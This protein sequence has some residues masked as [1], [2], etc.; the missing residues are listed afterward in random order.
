[1]GIDED[2][3][4][5]EKTVS[6]NK[7]NIREMKAFMKG[8]SIAVAIIIG[9]GAYIIQDMVKDIKGNTSKIEQKVDWNYI[10]KIDKK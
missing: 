7:M 1:M 8:L 9:L 5:I 3:K 10:N 6:E 4:E 2:L